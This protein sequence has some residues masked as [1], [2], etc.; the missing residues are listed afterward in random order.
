L[1]QNQAAAAV[2]ALFDDPELGLQ[3]AFDD[4]ANVKTIDKGL[5]WIVALMAWRSDVRLSI[6][7]LWFLCHFIYTTYLIYAHLF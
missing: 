7:G 3:H 1:L 5:Q 4:A 6:F 2:A